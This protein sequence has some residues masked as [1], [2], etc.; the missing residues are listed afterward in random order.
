MLLSW[1]TFPLTD[2]H[3]A[4][5]LCSVCARIDFLGPRGPWEVLGGPKGPL[6]QTSDIYMMALQVFVF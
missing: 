2:L 5:H 1:R 6:G 4:E 3:S